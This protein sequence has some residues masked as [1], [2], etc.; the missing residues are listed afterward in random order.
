MDLSRIVGD[1]TRI[2]RR[3]DWYLSTLAANGLTNMILESG[4]SRIQTAVQWNRYGEADDLLSRWIE[5]LVHT[6]EIEPVIKF[7]AREVSNGNLWATFRLLDRF[8]EC[9]CP[10]VGLGFERSALQ[11]VILDALI[12]QLRSNERP[13]G[14]LAR[15]QVEWAAHEISSGHLEK[16]LD[17]HVTE[18][19]A[20]LHKVQ[21]SSPLE[22]SLKVRLDLIDKGRADSA[23]SRWS[24]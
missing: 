19:Y 4:Y 7:V 11:C 13:K 24:K 20:F 5:F 3:Y 18:A 6:V 2:A 17:E 12:R 16:L 10:S 15:A 9:Q 23:G 1:E 22:E 14:L 21:V 8:G